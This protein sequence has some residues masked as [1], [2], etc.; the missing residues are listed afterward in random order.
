M[1]SSTVRVDGKNSVTTSFRPK[2]AICFS[3]SD[4]LRPIVSATRRA[5]ILHSFDHK[6]R[7]LCRGSVPRRRAPPKSDRVA[8]PLPRNV[9]YL[10]LTRRAHTRLRSYTDKSATSPD[11][12]GPFFDGLHN[13]AIYRHQVPSQH[14]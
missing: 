8:E 12:Q 11:H 6:C 7:V 9:R 3:R 10:R 1:L 5:T 14:L 13:S 4:R 2:E